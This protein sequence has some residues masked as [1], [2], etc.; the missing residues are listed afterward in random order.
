ML[1][2]Y[3]QETKGR[4]YLEIIHLFH[5][6]T[7]QGEGFPSYVKI[8]YRFATYKQ[9]TTTQGEHGWGGE[10]VR[11][12]SVP[13]ASSEQQ[14]RK[15]RVTSSKSF[16]LS[17]LSV[18]GSTYLVG[19]MGGWELSLFFPARG[20]LNLPS[21]RPCAYPPQFLSGTCVLMSDMKSVPAGNE[22][23]SVRG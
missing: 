6:Q 20:F 15:C 21:I 4:K 16:L 17:P 10:D 1:T 2:K 9:H 22:S 7:F 18:P 23:V 5:H 3:F 13:F 19:W 14:A 11:W 8:Y 12:G